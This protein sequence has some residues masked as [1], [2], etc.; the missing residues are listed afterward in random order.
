[1]I[2]KKFRN[3]SYVF[4]YIIPTLTLTSDSLGHEKNTSHLFDCRNR[5]GSEAC[6]SIVFLFAKQKKKNFFL[7]I[8]Q[9]PQT[10]KFLIDHHKPSNF[11]NLN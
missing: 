10:N 8:L 4:C 11:F 7:K 5:K 2:L 1:M 9:V 6:S 3:I